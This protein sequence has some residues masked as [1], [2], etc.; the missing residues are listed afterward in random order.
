MSAGSPESAA[1]RNGPLPSQKSGRMYS[2]TK[3]GMSNAFGDA[4]L[5]GLR[6]DVVAV[7][8]G[9]GAA[10]L[11]LEH[12]R[13]VR[14]HRR[15]RSPRRTRRV[16]AAQRVGLGEREA[17]R[18]VAVQRVV[19]RGLVGQH[20]GRDAARARVRAARPRRCRAAQSTGA[21]F[22]R[23]HAATVVEGV[24]ERVGGLVHVAGLQPALDP[25]RVHLDDQRDAAVHRRRERLGAAHAAEAGRDEHAALEAAA[26]VPAGQRRRASRRCPAGCPACR[27]R[28]S[29]RP[30]S[31]RTSSGPCARGRGS[32]PRWPTRA[33]AA[34][35]R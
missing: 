34:R 3:P 9:D 23:C 33:R 24:V 30:S 4:G 7:V 35:W 21:R 1:Q 13:D 6:A 11:Q 20:V 2:G 5:H 28:S 32:S 27:C 25:V 15:H 8:E 14:A 10:P 31:G 18:H 12:R 16:R 22:S 19:R 17:V 26:E 29:C